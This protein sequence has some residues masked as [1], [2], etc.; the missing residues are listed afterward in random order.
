MEATPAQSVPSQAKTVAPTP[1]VPHVD[2]KAALK[3]ES[4][5]PSPQEQ[6]V[7]YGEK[8]FLVG[9]IFTVIVIVSVLG[10]IY[11]WTQN[12]NQVQKPVS[13]QTTK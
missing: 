12:T 8:T 6:K 11:Y 7:S 3:I 13:V 2:P 1:E 5:T 4:T 10:I 9:T